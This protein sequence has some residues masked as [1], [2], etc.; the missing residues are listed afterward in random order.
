[1]SVISVKTVE[2][3]PVFLPLNVNQ[4]AAKIESE[5]DLFRTH[6]SE[7]VVR[8]RQS[9]LPRRENIQVAAIRCHPALPRLGLQVLQG[10]RHSHG[11]PSVHEGGRRRDEV[12]HLVDNSLTPPTRVEVH[13]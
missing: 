12:S 5:M 11:S 13:D 4:S 1:M 7:K 8:R 3:D 2:R 6:L 10:W 9:P